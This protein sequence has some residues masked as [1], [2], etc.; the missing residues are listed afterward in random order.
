MGYSD[1]TLTYRTMKNIKLIA[2]SMMALLPLSLE[3]ADEKKL[4]EWK[5]EDTVLGEKPT[6]SYLKGKVVVIEYWGVN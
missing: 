5:F 6:R 2:L 3:A 4:S 1:H